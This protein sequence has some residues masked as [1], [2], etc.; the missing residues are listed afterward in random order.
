LPKIIKYKD[1][2]QLELKRKRKKHLKEH[3]L[4]LIKIL[5]GI[6]MMKKIMI[7]YIKIKSEK[8]NGLKNLSKFQQKC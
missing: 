8:I 2:A 1:S 4:F 6:I 5:M 7:N 3:I